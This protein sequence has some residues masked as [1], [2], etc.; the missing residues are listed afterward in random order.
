MQHV[1]I[2]QWYVCHCALYFNQ[3]E[4]S[5]IPACPSFMCFRT[6]CNMEGTN[7][8]RKK[9]SVRCLYIYIWDLFVLGLILQTWLIIIITII[10][11]IYPLI[12]RVVRAPQM[13]SQPVSS[14]FFPFSGALWDLPN[15][16]P[17]HSLMLS[18][19]VSLCLLCLL[20]PFTVPCK[21]DGFG[22]TWWTGDMTIPLQFASLYNG[23]VYVWSIVCLT[24]TI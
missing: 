24:S 19:H 10:I 16:R 8:S 12:A 5:T 17:V 6:N 2:W 9:Q 3:T 23:Q 14:I 18:S 15:S 22:Q 13:I 11:I 1:T 20:P 7:S 4:G 21:I